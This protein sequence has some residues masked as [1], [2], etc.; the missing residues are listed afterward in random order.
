[1]MTSR[2]AVAALLV[3]L[4]GVSLTA[5]PLRTLASVRADT[6]GNT[7]ITITETPAGRVSQVEFLSRSGRA[8]LKLLG[9]L[10]PVI[11]RWFERDIA[12]ARHICFAYPPSSMAFGAELVFKS[13][14][15]EP[16]N[17]YR[18]R[19]YDICPGDAYGLTRRNSDWHRGAISVGAIASCG[20]V[21]FP[22]LPN[23]DTLVPL[24][25]P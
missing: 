25:G 9:H 17:E 22:P 4:V 20:G 21:A 11:G 2:P 8:Y 23:T 14:G 6:A 19:L 24:R 3:F 10:K 18:A 13:E 7:V 12:G 15:C 16:L 5:S 1:M